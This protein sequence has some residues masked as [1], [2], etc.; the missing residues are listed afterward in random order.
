MEWYSEINASSLPARNIIL[1]HIDVPFEKDLPETELWRIH[2]EAMQRYRELY[3][4]ISGAHR[5][6]DL[7]GPEKSLLDL[8]IELSQRVVRS[9]RLCQHRCM[10]DRCAGEKGFCRLTDRSGYASEFLHMGEEAQLV[11]SHT[12]FFT[13]CVFSCVFCQNWDISTRPESGKVVIP[14]EL[15]AII[16]HMREKGSLNVNFVT[17][18]P[19]LMNI[20]KTIRQLRN[21]IPVI[22][23]SNMYYSP[24]A[25]KLLEGV[26][27]LYLG[28]FKYGNDTCAHRYSKIRNYM[29][30]VEHN[31]KIASGQAEILIR[32]LL[33]PG[34]L[35]CCTRPI[36]RWIA[37]NTPHVRLNLMFQYRPE[38]LAC[39]YPEIN[40]HP[41]NEEKEM[42]LQIVREEGL[43]NILI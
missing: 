31:F 7:P 42:A 1:R 21:N 33:M 23:N 14:E 34:H 30:T 3:M 28:D 25:A 10:V 19:H 36:I 9:C 29:A 18:T 32:H 43:E 20:L 12:I 17:P 5:S 24:E 37:A 2:E 8:K 11:P 26:V 15:A 39:R 35:E 13:G 6:I 38:Y 16:D 40:R 27:D 22:W 4:K 41:T